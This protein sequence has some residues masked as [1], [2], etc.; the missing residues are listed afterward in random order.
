MFLRLL[1]TFGKQGALLLTY[2]YTE[3][4]CEEK[5]R[6]RGE[7]VH[8]Y[9]GKVYMDGENL[10]GLVGVVKLGNFGIDVCNINLYK[11]FCIF[12]GGGGV[13]MGF[14]VCKKYL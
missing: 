14:I 4:V 8:K 3:G 11:I 12:Y 9:G 5:R 10:N 6:E 13:G 2:P 1:K 7:L